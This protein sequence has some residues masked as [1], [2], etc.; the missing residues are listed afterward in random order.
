MSLLLA[1][2]G[3]AKK[4]KEGKG[5]ELSPEIV[6]AIADGISSLNLGAILEG[7]NGISVPE[8][9]DL[10]ES[11]E[12]EATL[13]ANYD[14][15]E[16]NLS[17]YIG[18]KDGI[19]KSSSSGE[20]SYLIIQ[21]NNMLSVSPYYQGGYS[22]TLENAGTDDLDLSQYL[23]DD[24]IDILKEFRFPTIKAN[25]ITKKGD[26]Y[27]V[28]D[29]YMQS[30]AK[31]IIDTAFDIAVE[32]GLP[33]SALPT[34][35]DYDELVETVNKALK[36]CGLKLGFTV[37]N[38]QVSGVVFE[39]NCT[40]RDLAEAFGESSDYVDD[41][42]ISAKFKIE[43]IPETLALTHLEV[44]IAVTQDGEKASMECEVDIS[45]SAD[46]MPTRLDVSANVIAPDST[47][48]YIESDDDYIELELYGSTTVNASASFDLTKL[49]TKEYG[50]LIEA[51]VSFSK[52]YNTVTAYTYDGEYG[53]SEVDPSDLGINVNLKDYSESGELELNANTVNENKM[54]FSLTFK[55][56]GESE[57]IRGT[58]EY[59]LDGA[60]NYGS[61][62]TFVR[63]MNSAS[64]IDSFND[65]N[66]DAE[67]I[68]SQL[69]EMEAMDTYY[70]YDEETGLYVLFEGCYYYTVLT[71]IQYSEYYT[72]IYVDAYGNITK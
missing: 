56:D 26:A 9:S 72:Q 57:T 54:S 44:S 43:Y 28:S 68:L 4:E 40:A 52:V 2:C 35:D 47:F 20:E 29:S 8:M 45:Y 59:N 48:D 70:L 27:M 17:G 14:T 63:K 46:N 41:T 61:V 64:F 3:S 7:L 30:V 34:G 11:L 16:E 37:K 18:F 67:Y 58:A 50:Q 71:E 60:Y 42:A 23:S 25:Q 39:I 1:S 22:L 10:L 51:S 53:Y 12:F 15:L 69:E 5:E 38:N 65:L 13:S 19:F 21:G 33:Q 31:E 49:Y 32:A 55:Q 6:E 62:P 36:A 66:N 24:I